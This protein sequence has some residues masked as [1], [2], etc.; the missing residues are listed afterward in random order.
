MSASEQIRAFV[1]DN[2]VVVELPVGIL[3]FAC[4]YYP[5]LE[6]KVPDKAKFARWIAANI[7]E[8]DQDEAGNSALHR[9]LNELFL[10]RIPT[11]C[12]TA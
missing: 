11:P 7:V 8:F 6:C 5:E 2:K 12:K 10:H 9:L 3:V 1:R 4:E